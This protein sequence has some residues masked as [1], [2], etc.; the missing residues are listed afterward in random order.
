MM[1][2]GVLVL[3]KVLPSTVIDAA[4]RSESRVNVKVTV[5]P[6]ADFP[7][8]AVTFALTSTEP[9]PAYNCALSERVLTLA[10]DL[11]SVPA[12]AAAVP[13]EAEPSEMF[14]PVSTV[15]TKP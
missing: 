3:V 15:P 7:V 14:P 4:A 10:L 6:A 11:K 9:A 5:W 2:A 13:A 8:A 1:F 12:K